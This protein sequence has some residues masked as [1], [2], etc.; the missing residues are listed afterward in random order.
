MRT[1]PGPRST[2]HLPLQ[3]FASPYPGQNLPV[4]VHRSFCAT[5][6]KLQELDPGTATP[7]TT[8]RRDTTKK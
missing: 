2:L 8:E 5:L 3:Q 7:A 4:G 6:A 1:K